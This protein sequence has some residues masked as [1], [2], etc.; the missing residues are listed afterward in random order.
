MPKP[1]PI[2]EYISISKK[3]PSKPGAKKKKP[4]KKDIDQIV[5]Q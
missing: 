2:E 4:V 3:R 5:I 1:L